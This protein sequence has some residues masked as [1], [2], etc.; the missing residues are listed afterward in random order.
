MLRKSLLLE[1]VR[2]AMQKTEKM[3]SFKFRR[4]QVFRSG[5]FQAMKKQNTFTTACV[6]PLLWVHQLPSLSIL[7]VGASSL[8]LETITR[9]SGSKV[10]RSAL[11]D[12]SSDFKNTTRFFRMK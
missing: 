1:R 3:L 12:C 4:K 6:L 7:A 2:C 8:S 10:L 9:F 11:N 5:S